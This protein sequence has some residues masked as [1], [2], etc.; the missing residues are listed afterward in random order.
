MALHRLS[1]VLKVQQHIM[2]SSEVSSSCQSWTCAMTPVQLDC[3]KSQFRM[4]TD[5]CRSSGDSQEAA[6]SRTLKFF[7]RWLSP[8]LIHNMLQ[9]SLAALVA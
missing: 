5:H 1:A 7:V 3:N 2:S 6:N 4:I 8:L 9:A